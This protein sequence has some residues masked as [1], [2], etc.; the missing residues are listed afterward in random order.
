VALALWRSRAPGWSRRVRAIA[1][2]GAAGAVALLAVAALEYGTRGLV[3]HGRSQ[4]LVSYVWQFYFKRLSFMDPSLSRGWGFRQVFIDGFYD[5]LRT[6]KVMQPAWVLDVLKWGSMLGLL[7]LAVSL[8]GGTGEGSGGATGKILLWLGATLGAA[9]VALALG[10]KFGQV[11]VADGIAGGLFFSIGDI[12]VKVATG[13]ARGPSSRS[14]WSPATRS[15]P[16]SSSSATRRA[17]R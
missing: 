5:P 8:A 14:A 9:L 16:R 12:S 11:G 17:A 13:E 6:A 10:R 15:A 2:V 3:G 4:Q 1:L 7:A